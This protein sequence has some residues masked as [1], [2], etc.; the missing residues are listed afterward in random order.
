MKS[1]PTQTNEHGQITIVLREMLFYDKI[2]PP[3][4]T[5]IWPLHIETAITGFRLG[6]EWKIGGQVWR[7]ELNVDETSPRFLRDGVRIESGGLPEEAHALANTV[8][9]YLA[10][11]EGTCGTSV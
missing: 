1:L 5:I 9:R 8:V 10:I 2:S 7:V 6:A 11:C 4:I 3:D